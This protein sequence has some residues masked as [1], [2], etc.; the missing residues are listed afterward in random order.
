MMQKRK[1]LFE[2]IDLVENSIN[3]ASVKKN[4]FFKLFVYKES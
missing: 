3:N 2:L 4:I 1:K